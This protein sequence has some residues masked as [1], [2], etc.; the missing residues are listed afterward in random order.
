MRPSQRHS[1]LV[2]FMVASSRE[3]WDSRSCAAAAAAALA[4]AMRLAELADPHPPHVGTALDV[5]PAE[6]AL[7]LR[8]ELVVQ[9]L[10]VVVVDEFHRL[11]RGEAAEGREDER[12]TVPRREVTHVDLGGAGG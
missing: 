5:V 12:V 1:L 8:L 3:S 11:A 10:R 4:V 7:K 6:L 2:D 9:G